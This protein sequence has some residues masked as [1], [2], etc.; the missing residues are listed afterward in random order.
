MDLTNVNFV[1]ESAAQLA[2]SVPMAT[3]KMANTT[4]TAGELQYTACDM[5]S[6]FLYI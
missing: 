1:L 2:S 5:Y 6:T 4:D 3:D